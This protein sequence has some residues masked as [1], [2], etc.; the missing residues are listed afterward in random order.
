MLLIFILLIIMVI[1]WSFS[2]VIVDIA[3]E[4]IP[5]MSIALY[6]FVV[7]SIAFLIIDLYLK[8][9]KK[10]KRTISNLPEENSKFSRNDWI[11]L[12]IASFTGVSI[13]FTVQYIAISFI[14]PSLPALFVCLLAPVLITVFSLI[15]H[16]GFH[17]FL[18]FHKLVLRSYYFSQHR[19]SAR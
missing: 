15:F 6:R 2:F 3:V 8:I 11:L 19:V 9:N 1:L 16:K 4:I 12:T 13:F 17:S 18:A 5:P 14:G 10:S 7:A